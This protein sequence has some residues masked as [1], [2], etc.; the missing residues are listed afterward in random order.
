MKIALSIEKKNPL[1][2]QMVRNLLV[3]ESTQTNGTDQHTGKKDHFGIG[4]PYLFVA[5]QILLEATVFIQSMVE[6]EMK[7]L[8]LAKSLRHWTLYIQVHREGKSFGK[9]HIS[10]PYFKLCSST[11]YTKPF[12]FTFI[13]CFEI[14]KYLLIVSKITS[15]ANVFSYTVLSY[16]H[17]LQLSS[18]E[19]VAF[20]VTG[21]EKILHFL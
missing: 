15:D 11:S 8:K 18:D 14:Q 17:E 5:D 13:E 21:V 2:I 7:K 10:R 19:V 4:G 20:P 6:V 3:R 9:C 12:L 1:H 16:T